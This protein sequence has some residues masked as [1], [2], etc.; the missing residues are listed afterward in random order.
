MNYL[1]EL[2]LYINHFSASNKKK[3]ICFKF[4]VKN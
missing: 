4:V 1:N 2:I 3:K